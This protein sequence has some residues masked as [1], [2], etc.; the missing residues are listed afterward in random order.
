MDDEI[1]PE[2]LGHHLGHLGLS[3]ICLGISGEVIHYYQDVLFLSLA[4]GTGNQYAL[5]PGDGSHDTFHGGPLLLHLEGD[6][7]AMILDVFLCLYGHLRPEEMVTHQV[8][9]SFKV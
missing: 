1:V 2:D 4:L 5:A 6:A 9:H 3:D 8:K 7:L